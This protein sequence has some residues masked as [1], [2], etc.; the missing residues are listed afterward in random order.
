MTPKCELRRINRHKHR[1]SVGTN[2]GAQNP[3]LVF[4]G[5]STAGGETRLHAHASLLVLLPPPILP[6]FISGGVSYLI[7]ANVQWKMKKR[8]RKGKK[9]QKGKKRKM[10]KRKP[11]FQSLLCQDAGARH[12]TLCFISGSS[13]PEIVYSPA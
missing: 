10:R 7:S 3:R 4:C 12:R 2:N 8:E 13:Q 1:N 11:G 6:R 9:G 5:D